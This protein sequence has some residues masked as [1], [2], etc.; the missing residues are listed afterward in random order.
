MRQFS[1]ADV[2]AAAL[3]LATKI[4]EHPVLVRK[5]VNVFDYIMQHDRWRM[6]RSGGG[7]WTKKQRGNM[8]TNGNNG[9][10]TASTSVF[11]WQP[12]SYQ[13]S[14]FYDYKDSLVVHEMQILKRL[15]FQLEAQL[16]YSTLVNYLQILGLGKE[17]DVVERCW[18][19]VTDM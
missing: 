18:A 12:H 13:S 8:A 4:E 7:W 10:A 19:I 2:S 14:V 6:E 1:V 16:P 3:Y 9:D 15:G 5:L 17:R 11:R